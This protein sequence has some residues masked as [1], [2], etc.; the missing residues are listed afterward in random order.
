MRRALTRYIHNLQNYLLFKG[1]KPVNTLR[2]ARV[3][4]MCAAFMALPGCVAVALTAGGL[5]AGAGVNHT[6][7][8]IAYKTFNNPMD[9][10]RG[11]TLV[12]LADMDMDV[13]TDDETED[14]WEIKA[15]AID[16]EIDIELER[17][18]S[19]TTR[20]RVVAHEGEIFFKDSATATEIIIVTAENL[21]S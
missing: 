5:A 13:T 19:T 15:T 20:M 2:G 9:E 17:L 16:R 12:T 7:S 21:T 3:A 4:L 18:T 6:L 11:A 10:M 14:G 8:G 1:M